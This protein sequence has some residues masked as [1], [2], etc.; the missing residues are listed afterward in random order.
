VQ[1][2][3]KKVF[4]E[5]VINLKRQSRKILWYFFGVIDRYEIS[6]HTKRACLLLNYVF[7]SKFLI[8]VSRRSELTLWVYLA[9]SPSLASQSYSCFSVTKWNNFIM[10]ESFFS[11]KKAFPMISFTLYVTFFLSTLTLNYFILSVKRAGLKGK[12]FVYWF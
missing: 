1:N 10:K 4:P 3:I 9:L 6:T 11:A 2:A 5:K 7:M 12:V 8:F